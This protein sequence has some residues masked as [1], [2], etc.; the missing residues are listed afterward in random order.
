MEGVE[1]YEG[2]DSQTALVA[3]GA[4]IVRLENSTQ[5]QV[6]ILHPRDEKEILDAAMKELDLYPSM[7]EEALYMKPVGKN[8]A[9]HMTY[10]EGLSI[11]AAESLANRWQNS[12]Y[13]CEIVRDDEDTVA[14]AAVFLDYQNNTR[15]VVMARVSKTYKKKGGGTGRR[16]GDRLELAV[17][18]EQSK[19][20]REVILR[21][22]PAGLKKEYEKKVRELL[23]GGKVANIKRSIVAR[24]AELGISLEVLETHRGRKMADWVHDDAV[25]LLGIANAIRDGELTKEAAFASQ[26]G[27]QATKASTVKPA[28][29]EGKKEEP[30]AEGEPS[31]CCGN[32][33]DCDFHR[34]AG[35]E[36]FCDHD[37]ANP[38][39]CEKRLP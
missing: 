23:S 26:E 24:F 9:G 8:D 5:M 13:G 28:G 31:W 25:I 7:A 12:S 18:A 21:S 1:R 30:K 36:R 29:N 32:P 27:E 20:L 2:M 3:S 16:D 35:D 4:S 14:L 17:K 11:R 10:A 22:L 6:A 34:F 19:A 37:P 38:V 15:H 39:A 33:V